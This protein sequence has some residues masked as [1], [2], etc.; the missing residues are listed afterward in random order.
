MISYKLV[1]NY[2]YFFLSHL[3]ESW[4]NFTNFALQTS[5]INLMRERFGN[6]GCGYYLIYRIMIIEYILFVSFLGSIVSSEL[7]LY[8][9]QNNFQKC[10]FTYLRIN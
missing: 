9:P 6:I 7:L 8:C 1:G 2:K 3:L 5:S 10:L 4:N